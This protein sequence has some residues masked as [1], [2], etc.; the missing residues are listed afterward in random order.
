V[1]SAEFRQYQAELLNRVDYKKEF[2]VVLKNYNI[3]GVMIPK[4]S[5]EI[6]ASILRNIPTKINCV[7]KLRH[8]KETPKNPAAGGA[9]VQNY[10]APT[11]TD[12]RAGIIRRLPK[13]LSPQKRE[14]SE[15]RPPI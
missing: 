15:D 13:A 12:G 5:T 1:A 8:P 3:K 14:E 11:N 4:D 7:R 2:V 10:A 9:G 6:V